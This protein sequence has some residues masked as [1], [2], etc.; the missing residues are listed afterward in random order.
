MSEEGR[1]EK[2][3][4]IKV[5]NHIV[6]DGQV[7]VVKSTEKSKAGKHG[8]AK[9]RMSVEHIITGN[10]KSLVMPGDDKLKIPHIDKKIAQ[11]ISVNP[12]SV[13]L[14]DKESYEVF[15]TA[16]PNYDE[17]GGELFSGDEVD[18]WIILGQRVIRKKRALD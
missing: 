8:H 15:E 6:H 5:G 9:V 3:T 1:P 4:Q 16:L 14:M 17:I 2:A 13:Q 11:V 10:K 12:D 7:F 18:F